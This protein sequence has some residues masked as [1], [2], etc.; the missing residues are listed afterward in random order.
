MASYGEGDPT[1]RQECDQR[2]ARMSQKR[3]GV[4]GRRAWLTSL[5]LPKVPTS[6]AF[7]VILAGS[8]V[9]NGAPGTQTD[10]LMKCRHSRWRL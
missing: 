4:L 8:W 1:K 6:T 5:P 3:K 9:R 10:T 7:P 2:D